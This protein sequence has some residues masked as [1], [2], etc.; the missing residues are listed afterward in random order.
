M[1]LAFVSAILQ[2]LSAILELIVLVVVMHDIAPKLVLSHVL[3]FE[4]L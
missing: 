2:D 3:V 1:Q 4:C